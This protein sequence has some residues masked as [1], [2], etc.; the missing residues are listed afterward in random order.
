MNWPLRKIVTLFL[1][2]VGYD[3]GLFILTAIVI[4]FLTVLNLIHPVNFLVRG[5]R[6][7]RGKPT[8]FDRAL[9]DSFRISRSVA[10]IE[11]TNSEVKG[12][13]SDDCNTEA[14]KYSL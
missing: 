7:G 1:R 9:T 3:H 14:I 13:C 10:R 11:P 8:T 4:T 5:N 6:S 12:A 2:P